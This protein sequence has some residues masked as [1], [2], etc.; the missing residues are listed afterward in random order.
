MKRKIYIKSFALVFILSIVFIFIVNTAKSEFAQVE[1]YSITSTGT[2]NQSTRQVTLQE[3][4]ASS[5]PAIFQYTIYNGQGPLQTSLNN[6]PNAV[7]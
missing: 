4:A 3:Q 2:Y 1:E 7:Q 5:V 6:T